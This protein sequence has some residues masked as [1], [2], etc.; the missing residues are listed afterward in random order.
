M[1][2]NRVSTFDSRMRAFACFAP[3]STIFDGKEE[4]EK[5]ARTTV[6]LEY[7]GK[8]PVSWTLDE[9]VDAASD[10]R[11]RSLFRFSLVNH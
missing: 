7:Q 5:A 8:T 6:R 2:A 1:V 3:L 11:T 4:K 9:R 10:F